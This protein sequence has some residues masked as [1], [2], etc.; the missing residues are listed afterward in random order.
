MNEIHEQMK[1][2]WVVPT[3]R[4]VRSADT[5][6]GVNTLPFEDTAGTVPGF[7]FSP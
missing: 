6:G 5:Q 4:C 2:P 1:Q 7:L 3:V